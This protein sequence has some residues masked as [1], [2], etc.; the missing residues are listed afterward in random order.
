MKYYLN[1]GIKYILS[2]Q[3]V[4]NEDA[5]TIV[6]ELDSL[7]RI[8]YDY[9]RYNKKSKDT[10]TDTENIK[11][12]SQELS[13]LNNTLSN[14]KKTSTN[15]FDKAINKLSGQVLR[16]SDAA[17]IKG[18]TKEVLQKVEAL[19]DATSIADADIDGKKSTTNTKSTTD[20]KSTTVK[21]YLRQIKTLAA[22]DDVSKE[23]LLKIKENVAKISDIINALSQ[24]KSDDSDTSKD[25]VTIAEDALMNVSNLKQFIKKIGGAEEFAKL[26]NANKLMLVVTTICKQQKEGKKSL[27]EQRQNMLDFS[28]LTKK[29]IDASGITLNTDRTGSIN[30]DDRFAKAK[31][32]NSFWDSYY[33]KAWGNNSN[34]IRA[35]GGPFRNQCEKLGFSDKTNP[36]ISFIRKYIIEKNYP[37]GGGVYTAIHNAVA[38]GKLSQEL[39]KGTV[40]NKINI[41]DCK[42]LYTKSAKEI[43]DYFNY[44]NDIYGRS[45]YEPNNIFSI[46]INNITDTDRKRKFKA[47]ISHLNRDDKSRNQIAWLLLFNTL[48][49]TNRGLLSVDDSTKITAYSA[50]KVE[51]MTLRSLAEAQAIAKILNPEVIN[52]SSKAFTDDTV[53]ALVA[54]MPKAN[55]SNKTQ[56][57]QWIL[58]MLGQFLAPEAEEQILKDYPK[59]T[60]IA[61]SPTDRV[62]Y[63]KQILDL[64]NNMTKKQ[65]IDILTAYENGIDGKEDTKVSFK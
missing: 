48:P 22:S 12:I 47:I 40:G 54:K 15:I 44:F 27:S 26:A 39:L 53:K 63:R 55:I 11:S 1:E 28:N 64:G 57:G 36:F 29:V 17:K 38:T 23:T 2:E 43:T 46:D 9:V 13:V 59:L 6:S 8:L 41:L 65:I 42:D 34:K 52:I 14:Y 30:W 16:S 58:V 45:E 19:L 20:T 10:S 62:K 49:F 31:D 24:K 61:L 56:I 25:L 21:D 51:T 33:E 60:E 32:K 3:F 35:L 7:Y 37:I 18:A 50:T 4:L 5:S